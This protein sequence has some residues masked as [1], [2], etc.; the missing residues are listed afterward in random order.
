MGRPKGETNITHSKEE[1]LSLV[2]RVLNG[3]TTAELDKERGC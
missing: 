1:K 3:E 2:K